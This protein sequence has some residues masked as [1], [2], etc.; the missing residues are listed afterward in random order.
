M[1]Q[2]DVLIKGIVTD[3]T[4]RMITIIADVTVLEITEEIRI[5][6]M[7]GNLQ[8]MTLEETRQHFK[9]IMIGVIRQKIGERKEIENGKWKR[10]GDF[11]GDEY[12]IE[13]V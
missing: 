8:D 1:V 3:P 10:A 9:D 4:C 2:A 7:V 5:S 13:V 6:E 11:I 12:T